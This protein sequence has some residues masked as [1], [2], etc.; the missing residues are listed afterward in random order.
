MKDHL[1]IQQIELGELQ[2]FNYLLGDKGT[3][4]IAIIDPSEETDVLLDL[5]AKDNLQIVAILLTHGHFDH[6]GGVVDLV[7][8]LEIPVYLSK[9][10]APFYT[11]D[12]RLLKKT[13]NHEKIRIGGITVECLHTPGHTPGCQCF[14]AEGNLFTGD[15]LFISAIG[16]SDFP[17][18]N[19]VELFQSLELIKKLPDSTLIWPGH[20]Y[21][22]LTTDTL[23]NLKQNNPYLGC[24]TEEEFLNL[25]G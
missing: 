15:T 7:D 8:R 4:E 2:N 24:S 17:G 22:R 6:V 10:E 21:G 3:R 19:T 13:E 12:C 25:A 20:N 5:A 1:Y 23:K 16:R 11:P 18:G 9:R 14:L